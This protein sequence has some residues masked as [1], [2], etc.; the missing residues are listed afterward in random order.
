M[1]ADSNPFTIPRA[2]FVSI[3]CVY[4]FLAFCLVQF[5]QSQ[6]QCR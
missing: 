2:L 4:V 5:F 3:V 1:S 6:S